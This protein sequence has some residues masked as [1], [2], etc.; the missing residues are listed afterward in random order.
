M[1]NTIGRYTLLKRLG[2]GGMG[3]VFLAQASPDQPPVVIKRVLPHL[4]ENPRFLRLFLD[5]T[6]IAARLNHPNIAR[7]IELG[8]ADGAWFIVMEHVE[9][10]DLREVLRR[11]REQEKQVPVNVAVKV[12][13][14]VAQGL[15]YAHSAVDAQ[16]RNLGI[17]HRDVSP[18]NVLLSKRGEAKVID[19]GV[20]KAT[21]KSVHTAA[22]ILKGKFPYMA[23]EQSRGKPV[24]ARTDVFALGIV[25]WEM[26]SGQFLFRGKTDAA[27]LK[28]VRTS[29]AAP[30][31]SLRRDVPAA[32]DDVVLKALAKEPDERFQTALEFQEALAALSAELP[33]ADVGAWLSLFD[34][35]GGV[36]GFNDFDDEPDSEVASAEA[37]VSQDP[38]ATVTGPFETS[39]GRGAFSVSRDDETVPLLS[40]QL[41]LPTNIGPQPTSFIGRVAE[42]ADLH[43]L[44]QHGSRLITLLGPGG[45]GKTR[46]SLQFGEQLVSHFSATG[47]NGRRRGGVWFCELGEATDLDGL[48]TAVARALGVQLAPGDTVEQLGHSLVARGEALL[49]LDNFEQLVGLAKDTVTKWLTAAPKIRFVISSREVL[50]VPNEMIFEVPPLRLPKPGERIQSAEAVELFVERARAVRPQWEPTDT[51]EPA[52]AEIVKQLDGLPLAIELAAA[53]MSVLSPTQ[54]VQRLP[55]RFELLIDKRAS[56]S[57]QATM[58][59]AIDWSWNML[60]EAE[61]SALAQL[62]VFRGGFSIEAL[63]AVVSVAHLPEAPSPLEALMALRAK[64]LVRAYFANGDEG[65][66]RF[67][68]YETLREYAKEKLL[69]RA[70]QEPA[71]ERHA[72]YYVTLGT[73]LAVNADSSLAKLNALDVERDNLFA[74]FQR[75]VDRNESGERLLQVVLALDPLLSI[76]GPFASHL[77]M[78]ESAL[79]AAGADQRRQALALDARARA[80]QAR[81][82]SADALADLHTMLELAQA[83]KDEALEG[84]A[85]AYAGLIERVQGQRSEARAHLTRALT[86]LRAT[87]DRLME[88]RAQS[89]LA[90]LLHDLGQETEAIAASNEAFAIHREVGDRRYQGITLTNLGVQQQSLGLLEQA[91]A[92]YVAALAIHRELGNRRSEGIS[93]INLGDLQRDL[94]RPRQAM[95]HYERALHIVREVGARRTEGIALF[96]VASLHHEVLALDEARAAYQEALVVLNE[97]H[98]TR[99]EGLARA[100]LAAVW[101]LKGKPVR[102]EEALLEATKQLTEVGDAAS[103]DALDVYR[104]QVELGEAMHAQSKNLAASLLARVDRRIEHAER[105]QGTLSPSARS[106]V[107]R[108]ALRGLKAA[109]AKFKAAS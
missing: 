87:K 16:G 15:A 55:R 80:R 48:V 66:P 100:G 68:L 19:F 109:L 44:F 84:R 11:A 37:A 32:L 91:K 83:L 33:T 36:D 22:G 99:H 42:L 39:S 28:L 78:I 58:R 46:L 105:A 74:V 106:D 14:D 30:L 31:R 1:V 47:E 79:H 12:A 90:F 62:S 94:K 2:A 97:V 10:K 59:G 8:E 88:G 107:V 23:P 7:I 76:R 13:L 45:T 69:G 95:T 63:N 29:A 61:A 60:T 4:V 98:A 3:E 108:A 92:N 40:D 18:H 77:T 67:G 21:N 25:L 75:S 34:D 85:L 53:R 17:V 26:V 52:I 27:T 101:A 96:S 89:F 70:E 71:L 93:H 9:G 49:I 35:V 65:V 82:R 103:L 57:R 102:A 56:S 81:G 41:A 86:L 20:A 104:G 5:E 6:R 51:D 72:K 24:D 50:R 64:S 38:D 54:L 43:Q 73:K